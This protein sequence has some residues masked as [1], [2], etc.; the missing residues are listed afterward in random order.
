MATDVAASLPDLILPPGSTITVTFDDPAA[1]LTKLNVFGFTPAP[2]DT[3]EIK[4]FKPL[5]AYG[6]AQ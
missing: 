3:A 6:V 2:E 4:P 1:N 5:F